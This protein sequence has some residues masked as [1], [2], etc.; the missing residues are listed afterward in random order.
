MEEYITFMNR[1][2]IKNIAKILLFCAGTV[3]VLGAV[4]YSNTRYNGFADTAPAS[5]YVSYL[6]WLWE[7]ICQSLWLYPRRFLNFFN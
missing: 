4:V 5:A 6:K 3:C 7:R 2:D 1:K